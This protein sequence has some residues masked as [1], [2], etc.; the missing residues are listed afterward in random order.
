MGLKAASAHRQNPLFV[1][2]AYLYFVSIQ[3]RKVSPALVFIRLCGPDV[4][5][6]SVVRSGT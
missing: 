6:S 3:H 1:T 2:S 5:V 4:S